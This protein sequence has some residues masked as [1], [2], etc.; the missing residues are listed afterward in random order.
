MSMSRKH[1]EALAGA[2]KRAAAR[3]RTIEE[4]QAL[5]RLAVEVAEILGAA[6]ASFKPDRF[7]AACQFPHLTDPR[8]SKNGQTP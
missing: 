4:A 2:F 6:S 7:L 3:A 8:E 5:G 1:Y